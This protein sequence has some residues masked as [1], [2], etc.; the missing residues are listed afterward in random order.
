MQLSLV[1]VVL[2][3][4]LERSY[5]PAF[6]RTAFLYFCNWRCLQREKFMCET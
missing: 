4:V 6:Y 5:C 3:F 1:S 2:C